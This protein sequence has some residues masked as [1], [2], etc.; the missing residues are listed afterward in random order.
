M[1]IKSIF[2][3]NI[4]A[5]KMLQKHLGLLLRLQIF[6][7]QLSHINV[8]RVVTSLMIFD[9]VRSAVIQKVCDNPLSSLIFY[10]TKADNYNY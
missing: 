3:D 10:N 8:Q 1:T 9:I 4:P 6:G 5:L 7:A 2:Y